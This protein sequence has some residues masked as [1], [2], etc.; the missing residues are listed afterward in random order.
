MHGT[1]RALK[2]MYPL[3]AL[4][5]ETG[6]RESASQF[7]L[8]LQPNMCGSVPSRGN[9]C[10]WVSHSGLL[11][12]LTVRLQVSSEAQAVGLCVTLR[13]FQT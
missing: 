1:T 4:A 6:F 13:L 3:S 10:S 5:L 2:Q 11:L 8:L 9:Q 12:F 7:P